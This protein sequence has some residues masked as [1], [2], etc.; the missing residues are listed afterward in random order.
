MINGKAVSLFTHDDGDITP[1]L[2]I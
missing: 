2:S 1:Y